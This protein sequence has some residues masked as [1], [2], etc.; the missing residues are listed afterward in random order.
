M[1]TYTDLKNRVKETITVG[2]RPED[3]VTMQKVRFYNEENEYYGSFSGSLS[4]KIDISKGKLSS[5][6]VYNATLIDPVI[7]TSGGMIIELG[8]I[9]NQLEE[10]SAYAH[11]DLSG[12]ISSCVK[13]IRDIRDAISAVPVDTADQLSGISSII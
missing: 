1:S 5:V 4:G 2:F 9:A 3:R 11:E 10:L 8:Q 12:A 13:D 6:D 7:K